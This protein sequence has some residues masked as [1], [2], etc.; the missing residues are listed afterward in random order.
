MAPGTISQP[1]SFSRRSLEPDFA[2]KDHAG[3]WKLRHPLKSSSFTLAELAGLAESTSSKTELSFHSSGQA[4]KHVQPSFVLHHHLQQD[5]TK[6][7]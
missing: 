2:A 6:R 7:N 4:L 1:A 5:G 3:L